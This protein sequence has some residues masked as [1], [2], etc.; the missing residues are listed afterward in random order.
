MK[1]IAVI[2]SL[3]IDIVS[4]V[5]RFPVPGESVVATDFEIFIG[6]GKGANQACA[7]GKLGGDVQLFGKTSRNFYGPDYVKKLESSGVDCAGVEILEE[8][9]PGIGLVAVDQKGENLIQVFPGANGK[10]DIEQMKTEKERISQCDIL[11]LQNEI[12]LETNLWLM[13]HFKDKTII[14]DPA[15]AADFPEEFFAHCEY[16]T[17]N[18]TELGQITGVPCSGENPESI[19]KAASVLL[20]MGVTRVLAKS[21]KYGV[22]FIT[23]E[24][25][26]HIPGYKV[27]AIDPTAAGDSFNGGLAYALAAGLSEEDSLGFANAVAGISVTALGAQSAMPDLEQVKVFMKQF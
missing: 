21:G 2:G 27:Q 16:V 9:F 17:P 22:F 15:P 23:R 4:A 3:N 11:L 10:V 13:N 18:E 24:G 14:L 6:G 26:T 8:G 7:A 5:D 12:P 1:K 20:N 19:E 25:M